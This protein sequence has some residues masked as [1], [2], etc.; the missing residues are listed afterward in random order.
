MQTQCGEMK[1]P[2]GVKVIFEFLV[3]IGR[4]GDVF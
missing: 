3:M 4:R 2:I 1:M